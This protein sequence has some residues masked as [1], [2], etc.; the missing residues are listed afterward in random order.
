[1]EAASDDMVGNEIRL[2]SLATTNA[3]SVV[4][5]PAIPVAGMRMVMIESDCVFSAA[6]PMSGDANVR[7]PGRA[8]AGPDAT[9]NVVGLVS[10]P[11]GTVI[12]SPLSVGTT[13]G[14]RVRRPFRRSG[15]RPTA[16]SLTVAL[17]RVLA[18]VPPPDS[19]ADREV[20]AVSGATQRG[21]LPPSRR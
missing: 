6:M 11:G 4:P 18:V 9:L 15:S 1:M 21:T 2:L 8:G 3:R 7:S 16:T 14:G 17:T 10:A 13:G 5:A 20:P 12:C 19:G